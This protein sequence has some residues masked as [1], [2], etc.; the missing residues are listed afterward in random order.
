MSGEVRIDVGADVGDD[1][2]DAV[3]GDVCAEVAGEVGGDV[4]DGVTGDV[5]NCEAASEE[6]REEENE[7]VTPTNGV[8]V[9][10][11]RAATGK[12]SD[13]TSSSTHTTRDGR[14]ERCGAGEGG[15]N[16]GEK[17]MV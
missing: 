15:Q 17:S 6:V 11:L 16:K 4:A 13:S 7:D 10:L 2:S 1:V 5:E 8:D 9:L 14:I 3:A 12:D